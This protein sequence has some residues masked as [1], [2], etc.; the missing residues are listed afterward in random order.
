MRSS[1]R[2]T[3]A[4]TTGFSASP[5]PVSHL[6]LQ[7]P[8]S[9]VAQLDALREPSFRLHL[10]EQLLLLIRASDALTIVRLDLQGS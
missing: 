5:Q 6:A 1:I 3:L 2:I 9:P 10:I 8:H 4:T 7:P